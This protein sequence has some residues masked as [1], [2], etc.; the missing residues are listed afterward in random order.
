VPL[1]IDQRS[2]QFAPGTYQ[3]SFVL[4][5]ITVLAIATVS[6]RRKKELSR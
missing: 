2:M 4:I 3:L 1:L 6:I 5:V